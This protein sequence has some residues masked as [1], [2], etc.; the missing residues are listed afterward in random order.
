M[1]GPC[2]AECGPISINRSTWPASSIFPIAWEKRTGYSRVPSNTWSL[3]AFSGVDH[4]GSQKIAKRP[5]LEESALEKCLQEF[6]SDNF[7]TALYN[8][9]HRQ[10]YVMSSKLPSS[11]RV[12]AKILFRKSI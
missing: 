10:S 12:L 7:D 8:G 2:K 3:A 5:R 4:Q 1:N 9:C 6:R 11:L